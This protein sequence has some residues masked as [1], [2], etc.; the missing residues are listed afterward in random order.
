MNVFV[1]YNLEK[2]V[3]DEEEEEEEE[4]DDNF[5]AGAKKKEEE[6]DPVARKLSKTYCFFN[7]I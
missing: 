6:Q 5:G 4:D 3:N 1:Q 2:P 7:E